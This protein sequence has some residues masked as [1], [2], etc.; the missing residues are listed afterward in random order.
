MDVCERR[1][2][3]YWMLFVRLFPSFS[4]MA[5]KETKTKRCGLCA[6]GRRRKR[7]EGRKKDEGCGYEEGGD[8]GGFD[9]DVVYGSCIIK[10]TSLF[11]LPSLSFSASPLLRFSS[12]DGLTSAP[13]IGCT[14]SFA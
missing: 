6:T 11:S 3:V 2:G 7:K 4:K 5:G 9:S 8:R 12:Y 1:P 10:I 13:A 14:P